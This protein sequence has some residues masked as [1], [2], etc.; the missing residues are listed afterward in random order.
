MT[1]I[2]T[3]KHYK[4]P[5]LEVKKKDGYGYYGALSVSLESGKLQCHVCGELFHHVGGHAYQKHGL[6]ASEYRERYKL[7]PSSSLVSEQLREQ[8]KMNTIRF[9][10]NLTRVQREA[11]AEAARKGRAKRDRYQ[12][13]EALEAKNRKGTCPDQLLETIKKCA[14]DIG[15]TPSK[16]EFIDYYQSQRYVHLIY[17]TF[18]SWSKALEMARLHPKEKVYNG[19]RRNYSD[20]ELLEYLNIFWQENQKIPTETD[21]RRG[22]I[23]D[24][25]IYKN[26][27]GSLPHARQLAGIQDTPTRWGTLP[28]KFKEY[29][30]I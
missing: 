24:S 2:L 1:E 17:K 10:A 20:E 21:C 4:E 29:K 13:K 7:S 8:L 3:L 12:P 9:M 25:S 23:P 15:H 18:G 30:L 27:F 5:L 14:D 16:K 11:I 22:L 6:K 28:R 26:R 19:G